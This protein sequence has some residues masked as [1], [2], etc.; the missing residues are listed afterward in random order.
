MLILHG[1]T[2]AERKVQGHV[3]RKGDGRKWS[4]VSCQ[5][6]RHSYIW[7]SWVANFFKSTELVSVN[8]IAILTS[9]QQNEI[10]G[11]QQIGVMEN[12]M[13]IL[14]SLRMETQ[15]SATSGLPYREACDQL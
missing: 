12:S 11:R 5:D 13:Y 8:I 10:L 7:F 3:D 4:T 14:I 9:T 6:L 2:D 1:A 15:T